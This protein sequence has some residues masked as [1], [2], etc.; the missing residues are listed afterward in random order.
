MSATTTGAA[1]ALKGALY[2]T[3]R[4]PGGLQHSQSAPT[5]LPALNAGTSSSAPAVKKEKV[6]GV[7]MDVLLK[8]LFPARL[9][10]PDSCGR[11]EIF[12]KFGPTDEDGNLR[13][14]YHGHHIHGDLEVKQMV[15]HNCRENLYKLLCVNG[16]DRRTVECTV[17][18][19]M[20]KAME[21]RYTAEEVADILRHVPRYPGTSRMKFTELQETIKKSQDSR[22]GEMAKRAMSGKPIAPP[23]E[24]PLKVP[25][26][27]RPAYELM[28]VTRKKKFASGMEESIARDR[29]LHSYSTLCAGIEDQNLTEQVMMSCSMCRDPGPLNDRWDRYCALRRSGRS[30]Y[31]QTRNTYRDR[32]SV[33]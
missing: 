5:L 6:L 2:G 1:G 11:L 19:L 27:S 4:L 7:S 8:F 3:G 28:A 15:E 17:D 20:P 10:N 21:Q 30:S 23:K 9:E 32:K 14:G 16:K 13:G 26:Q 24:R 31:V 12:G 18:T 25:F 29:R 33:V 22:L